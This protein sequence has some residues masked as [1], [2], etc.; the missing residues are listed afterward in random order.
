MRILLVHNFYGS[1]APSGENRVVLE[2]RDLLRE[3]GH[4][5]I[6]HFAYSDTVR[7]RGLLPLLKTALQV[8]WNHAARR[9]LARRVREVQPDIVH[10]HNVFPLFSPAIFGAAAGG[11]A[12]VIHT[13]HN[14]RVFCPGA[15][16]LR[17]NRV[18]TDCVERRSVIPALEHGCYRRSRLATA[19]LA[20][21]VALHRAL[22]TYQRHVDAFIALTEFQKEQL[23]KA[24][25]PPE[26]IF[27][28]ANCLPS[29]VEPVPWEQ[30]E[31]K[32]VFV[33]RISREKGVRV[34]L[35]AWAAW[36]PSAPQLQIIGDG[37]E[38]E[39]LR[40][41]APTRVAGR[42]SF[43]GQKS[44][45]DTQALLSRARVLIMPSICYEGFPLVFREAVGYGVPVIASR[46]GALPELVE[47]H[48][49]GRLFEAGNAQSLQQVLSSLWRDDSAL[50]AISTAASAEARA[51]YS[52]QA[53]LAAFDAIY[54]LAL[55]R[56]KEPCS[57]Q[58]E[59][60]A[61]V[62]R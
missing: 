19:P 30:R 34:L 35:D 44:P 55:E 14:Y 12:A 7:D 23:S 46:I 62:T 20:A 9:R 16:L 51:R 58:L 57:G 13:L 8:P 18:C 59:C 45:E 24:G 1:S 56:K 52:P 17:D 49:S 37:P 10:V 3:A 48:G 60:R 31:E 25:L 28:K 39:E 40:S 29:M 41:A 47:A 22:G 38:L 21:C 61:G 33:G 43:C 36:G 42:I 54:G 15:L 11:R 6:E 4:E 50:R 27:V 2:E 26:R 53:N 32:C 5:I